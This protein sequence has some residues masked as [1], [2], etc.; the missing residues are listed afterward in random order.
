MVG[1]GAAWDAMRARC[2]N[3]PG[4]GSG[5]DPDEED[6][7]DHQPTVP[8]EAGLSGSTLEEIW[9]L[10]Q[11]PLQSYLDFVSSLAVGSSAMDRKALCDEWR[12]AND[13]YYELESSEAGL[14]DQVECR[15]LDPSLAPLAEEVMADSRFRHT[16]DALPTGFAMVELDRLVV[17]QLRVTR[18]YVDA[19]RDRLGRAPTGEALFRFCMPLGQPGADLDIQRLGSRRYAFLSESLDLRFHESVLLEA[20]QITGYSSF[21]PISGVIGLIVGFGSNFLNVARA[22]DRMLL[23]DGYHRACALRALGVTHAPCVVQAVTRR[24]ELALVAPRAVVEAPAFY[25]KAKR[26]PLLKDFFDPR[27]GKTLQVRRTKRMIEVSFEIRESS[28]QE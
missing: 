15:E 23:L 5:Q 13:Y 26:P 10:G 28:F 22:D 3:R 11:P 14:A 27:I 20:N 9:L 2:S 17:A 1:G 12:L 21:G 7:I 24:D 4:T 8:G 16:F 25:F 6:A 18:S 19:L